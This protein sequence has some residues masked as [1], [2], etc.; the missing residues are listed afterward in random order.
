MFR[1]QTICRLSVFHMVMSRMLAEGSRLDIGVPPSMPNPWSCGWM[2]ESKD[3]IQTAS[4][5][6]AAYSH[7]Q[8]HLARVGARVQRDIDEHVFRA[9]REPSAGS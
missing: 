1:W 3:H 4:R 7:S 2:R 9:S 5:K 6:S 8:C